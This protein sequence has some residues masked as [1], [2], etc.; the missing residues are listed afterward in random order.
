VQT[1]FSNEQQLLRQIVAR[2]L[3]EKSPPTAV[4]ELMASDRGYDPAVW[5]ELCGDV[6][7]TG[8]HIPET[9]GGTGSG[10]I[11]LGIVAEEMG[12]HL[13]C[14]PFFSSA[15]MA[16]Y[17][18]LGAADEAHRRALLPGVAAGSSLATLALD[19]VS[20]PTRVGRSIRASGD[21]TLRGA[22]DI[23]LDAHVA[24]LLLVVARREQGTDGLALYAVDRGVRGVEVEPLQAL[25]PTRKL[26]RVTFDGAAGEKIGDVS[27]EQLE[28]MW[29]RICTALAHEMIGG[30]QRLFES[31]VEYTKV[32]FQFGRPIGSF[33]A[34][35]HRCAD[36]LM[37][38]ELARAATHH[39]ARCLDTGEGEPWAASMAKAMAADVYMHAAKEAIQLRGGIGFT[40]EDDTHL[41]FKRAKSSEVFMGGPSLHRERMMSLIEAAAS[42]SRVE[43][44]L[45][46]VE[47]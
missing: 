39:A 47:R 29:D 13:Y 27:R 35:K 8:I 45:R 41:W 12:R 33:Q 4:R 36:L 20:D 38:L 19:D 31:T 11:E 16:G 37:E 22:A 9:Y 24:T 1:E 42:T 34:L 5:Q 3:K 6:G 44:A 30:A 2:A 28:R 21:G 7:L 26:S 23:V 46:E 25:D 10:A 14:G 40:W 32:R 17:A 18:L 43:A 15:V